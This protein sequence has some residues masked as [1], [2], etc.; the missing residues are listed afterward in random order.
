M[1]SIIDQHQSKSGR[2]HPDS[3]AA[4]MSERSLDALWKRLGV[5][6]ATVRSLEKENE[7]LRAERARAVLAAARATDGANDKGQ[8]ATNRSGSKFEALTKELK[9]AEAARVEAAREREAAIDAVSDA[10]KEE[11]SQRIAIL[12]AQHADELTALSAVAGKQARKAVEEELGMLASEVS[13][14]RQALA[15]A[16]RQHETD[17]RALEESLS[18]KYAEQIEAL[19]RHYASTLENLSRRK[20]EQ[21]ATELMSSLSTAHASWREDTAAQLR[22]ATEAAAK[23]VKDERRRWRRRQMLTL[24][25]AARVWRRRERGRLREA[26]AQWELAQRR[27]I[28]ACNARWRSKLDRYRKQAQLIAVCSQASAGV[29]ERAKSFTASLASQQTAETGGT[30]LR[31]DPA[32]P[33]R[34]QAA[35]MTALLIFLGVNFSLTAGLPAASD[36]SASAAAGGEAS[37]IASV[38]ADKSSAAQAAAPALPRQKTPGRSGSGKDNASSHPAVDRAGSPSKEN[39]GHGAKASKPEAQR[40]ARYTIVRP[41]KRIAEQMIR[42]RLRENIRNLRMGRTAN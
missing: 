11:Y 34:L 16:G 8:T 28:D 40:P 13:D 10:L 39:A 1:K 33:T 25:R 6:E 15:I 2:E 12:Q 9:L 22:R 32:R 21:F 42:E 17:L 37:Q 23:A 36:G 19:H 5:A 20:K 29:W 18:K 7:Q 26:R 27:A 24:R 14:A 30:I 35:L 4:K 38:P 41:D 31:G 3:S